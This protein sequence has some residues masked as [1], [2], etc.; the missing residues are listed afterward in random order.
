MNSL[1]HDVTEYLASLIRQ[2]AS[3]HTIRNYRTDLESW[4]SFLTPQGGDPPAIAEIELLSMREWLGSLHD[5]N[6]NPSSI[7]RKLS[8]IRSF[9]TWAEHAGLVRKNVA[10]MLRT[11]K[12][13]QKL[14][15]VPTVEI[16]SGLIDGITAQAETRLFPARDLAICE[17]IYGAGI[18]I[19]E[20]VAIDLEDVEIQNRWVRI[21]GKGRKERLIPFTAR[22]EE[23]LRSYLQQRSPG[24]KDEKAVFLSYRGTRISDRG[25]RDIVRHYSLH[26]LDD[27]SIHPHTLRHAYA[28]HMLSAGADLRAIQELL[29]HEKLSTTQRY[30]QISLTDV[31]KVYDRCH[32]KA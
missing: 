29:G 9:F 31:M 19:A 22:A 15:A 18:R 3:P 8:A 28:T 24:S 27:A 11:P 26:V 14:P 10:R 16:T 25:A 2:N 17:L 30:T 6:L 13:P 20:L 7:R 1:H 23:A 4:V 12:A 5:Q 21:K 32:P